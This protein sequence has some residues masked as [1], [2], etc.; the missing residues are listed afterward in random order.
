MSCG[1]N[2]L[3]AMCDPTKK[4]R[5]I[6]DNSKMKIKKNLLNVGF[7]VALVKFKLTL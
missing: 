1:N 6:N 3:H 2:N 5:K 4:R 7:F